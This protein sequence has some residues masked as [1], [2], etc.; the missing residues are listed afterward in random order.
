M[1]IITKTYLSKANTIIRN[2]SANTS[3]NPVVELNYGN[4]LTRAI[5]YFDHTKLK[6]L[7]EDKTYP[8]ISKLK[9]VLKMTNTSSLTYK[10]INNLCLDTEKQFYKERAISFDLIFFLINKQWD[11]G[12]GFDYVMD[13]HD[14]GKKS[15]SCDASSWYQYKNFFK[16]DEEG[17]YSTDTLSKE[18]DKFTSQNG[19]LSKIIIAQKHFQYGN[20]DLEVDITDTVNKF[21]NDEIPNY[22]IG[23]AFSPRFEEL[24]TCLSQ[25]VGFFTQHTHSFFEPYVETTYDEYIEDDR[26]NFYLDKDNKLYFYASVGGNFV[27]LDELP[28]CTV[29]GQTYEVKQSTKG[30][31]Y[32]ELNLSSNEYEEDTMLYDTWSNIKYNG[33]EFKDSELSF[34]TKASDKHFS[35]GLPIQNEDTEY[36]PSIYGIGDHEEIKQ[37]DIRK[38]NIECRIPYTSNQLLATE[39]MDYR[40]Y[41]LEE[42]KQYEVIPWTKVERGFNENYF[43]VNTNEMVPSRYYVDI[44]IHRNLELINHFKILEFDVAENITEEFV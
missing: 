28:T 11:D 12:R 23:I 15:F 25:Y 32:I 18:L 9:H 4:M 2:S 36:V 33:K 37:G 3:L 13:M 5:I 16:W 43:L 1:A 31:Y 21:I 42:T 34:V 40:I 17:V 27:N 44:R 22:G 7:V 35:F 41:V 29:N 6:K 38:V 26:T 30:I 10:K 20:E 8:D 19:N 14:N 24:E 39:G